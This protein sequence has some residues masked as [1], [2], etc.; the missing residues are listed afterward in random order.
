MSV[1]LR[2]DGQDLMV[3]GHVFLEKIEDFFKNLNTFNIV[4]QDFG[5]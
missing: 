2:L 3:I 1:F 5:A 4:C